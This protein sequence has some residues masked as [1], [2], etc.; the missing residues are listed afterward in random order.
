MSTS[1]DPDGLDPDVRRRVE[2]YV[3]EWMSDDGVPGASVAVVEGADLRYAEGFGARDL[4]DDRPATPDTLYGIGSCTKSFVATATLQRAAAGD[5]SL[6]DPVSDYLPHLDDAPGDPVTLAELL[7][8][9]SGMP[10]DGNLSA[11]V[12][13][14]T[15]IGDANVPLT[16]DADF[17]RHVAD[18][19]DE[20][21]TAADHFFYYNTG[22]T[23]LGKV[24]EEVTGTDFP[25]YLREHVFDPLSMERSGFDPDAVAADDDRMTAYYETDDGWE[26]GSLGF[27]EAMDAP[28]GLVSSVTET[29]RHLRMLMGGGA[30]DGERVLPAEAVEEMTTPR[31]TRYETVGGTEREYGYG[32]SVQPFCGDTL[33]GHGGMMGTTTAFLGWL[34]DAEVGV[35]VACNTAP[36]H[37]PTVAG[38]AVLSILDGRDPHEAVGRLALERAADAVVGEYESYRGVQTA[39]VER[40]GTTLSVEVEGR[41]G[42]R[43]LTL[44]PEVTDDPTDPTYY[45]VDGDKR[46]TVEFVDGPDDGEGDGGTDM[47]LQRWRLHRRHE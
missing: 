32:L 2:S 35:V 16:S 26:E 10:S 37:H 17:R 8:H 5:L 47:L 1:S 24:I 39:T 12:T 9:T 31:V 33:V 42:D 23:L 41:L 18:S 36:D 34:T 11:L 14:L 22:F 13:R 46:V 40:E 44:F 43:S 4:A 3:T 29:S 6:S 7:S 15:D 28:G 38:H 30:F 27:A 20:R 21:Y 25:D 19:A 45:A